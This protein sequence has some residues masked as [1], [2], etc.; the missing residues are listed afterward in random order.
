MPNRPHFDLVVDERTYH[1]AQLAPTRDT[2]DVTWM[3]S[4]AGRYVCSVRHGSSLHITREE[5]EAALIAEVRR[6]AVMPPG[7]HRD[8]PGE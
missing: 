5:L 3:V 4:C 1:V 2:G 7:H 6:A 8:G